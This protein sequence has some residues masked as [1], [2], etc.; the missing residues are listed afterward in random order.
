MRGLR[1]PVPPERVRL[2]DQRWARVLARRGISAPAN[3]QLALSAFDQ[4]RAQAAEAVNAKDDQAIT[5]ALGEVDSAYMGAM[6]AM[7]AAQDEANEDFARLLLPW[8]TV[9][10]RLVRGRPLGLR[11]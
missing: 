8:P 3:V 1:V 6:S 5:T 11:G 9:V 4:A 2:A 7:R 10:W